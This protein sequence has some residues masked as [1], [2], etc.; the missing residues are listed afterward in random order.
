MKIHKDSIHY[1]TY[2]IFSNGRHPTNLCKYVRGI[3]FS[4]I[5]TFAF[6]FIGIALI[7]LAVYPF[8]YLYNFH[9]VGAIGH[10]FLFF[11]GA[12]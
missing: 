2:S 12:L 1:K 6:A 4:I 11:T 5:M 10:S 9:V 8:Y 3:A 7:C